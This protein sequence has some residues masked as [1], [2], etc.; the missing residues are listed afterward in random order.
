MEIIMKRMFAVTVFI[1]IMLFSVSIAQGQGPCVYTAQGDLNGDCV[2]N[3]ADLSILAYNWLVDCNAEPQH[4]A[5]TFMPESTLI[6]KQLSQ[7]HAINIGLEL[8]KMDFGVYPPSFENELAVDSGGI[9]L[10]LDPYCGSNK[11]TEAMMGMDMLGFH[12]QSDFKADAC[13]CSSSAGTIVY[14]AGD[15][16]NIEDRIDRLIDFEVSN[17][18]MMR[19]VYETGIQSIDT[20]LVLCDVFEK[21]RTSG[22]VTGMPILYYRARTLYRIQDF[23]DS[24]GT[25]DDVFNYYDNKNLLD[26]GAMLWMEEHALEHPMGADAPEGLQIFEQKILNKQILEL[27]GYKGPYNSR[28]FILISAGPDGLYGTEDDIFNFEN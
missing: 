11:L 4:P 7:F 20:S 21:K 8:F 6:V 28:S 9:S 3:F 13:V 12:P 25:Q 19:D 1:A 23:T 14:D 24:L 18:Y 22:K 5:C 15:P 10:G 27:T 16:Q 2:V 17:V 26:L